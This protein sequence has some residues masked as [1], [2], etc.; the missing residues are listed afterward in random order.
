MKPK[1]TRRLLIFGCNGQTS[2]SLIDLKT[3]Q[4][5]APSRPDVFRYLSNLHVLECMSNMSAN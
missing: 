1:K 5:S 4:W 3:L 2:K